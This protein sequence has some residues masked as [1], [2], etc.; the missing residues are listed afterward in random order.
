MTYEFNINPFDNHVHMLKSF[1]DA[2]RQVPARKKP[3][4]LWVC[5]YNKNKS[6]HLTEC[7]E[8][9]LNKQGSH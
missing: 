5:M 7:Q 2:D 1:C 9:G 8:A 3:P 4:H 6:L